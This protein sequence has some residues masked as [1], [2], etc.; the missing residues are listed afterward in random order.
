MI[1]T[2]GYDGFVV[3]YGTIESRLLREVNDAVIKPFKLY[4]VSTDLL[5]KDDISI[6]HLEIIPETAPFLRAMSAIY[7]RIYLPESMTPEGYRD[8]AEKIVA[9]SDGFRTCTLIPNRTLPDRVG[10][11]PEGHWKIANWV[12]LSSLGVRGKDAELVDEPALGIKG[13]GT[14]FD[15]LTPQDEA[16]FSLIDNQKG[17]D[18]GEKMKTLKRLLS[19]LKPLS[20][21]IIPRALQDESPESRAIGGDSYLNGRVQI[22]KTQQMITE[23][24]DLKFF[25]VIYAVTLPKFAIKEMIRH[26][27]EAGIQRDFGRGVWMRRRHLTSIT[28]DV[29]NFEDGFRLA[30]IFRLVFSQM[31]ARGF[32]EEELDLGEIS[33]RFKAL[34]FDPEEYRG[35]IA[36]RYRRDFRRMFDAYT[37]FVATD[38]PG[39]YKHLNF[40]EIE[41]VLEMKEAQF[42]RYDKA[43]YF[44]KDLALAKTGVYMADLESVALD[45]KREEHELPFITQ[46]FTAELFKEWIRLMTNLRIA[47]F[48]VEGNPISED[49]YRKIEQ[50]EYRLLLAELQNSSTSTITE[51]DDRLSFHISL[52]DQAKQPT[53]A[54]FDVSVEK[55]L[56]HMRYQDL[57]VENN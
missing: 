34:A 33:E 19:F 14:M 49:Q 18:R 28:G 36:S 11:S 52:L 55:S 20:P 37:R 32:T 40:R 9:L 12:E 22:G 13:I 57:H 5:S 56:F 42:R 29:K 24:V 47:S 30:H 2:S 54:G 53:Q 35:A 31:R 27:R 8:D 16:V 4:G 45:V 43:F 23:Q 17:D 1:E 39:E 51:Q 7:G 41:Y 6:A 38:I 48:T 10:T 25:P 21:I 15:G 44:A 26:M 50:E 46:R 3:F